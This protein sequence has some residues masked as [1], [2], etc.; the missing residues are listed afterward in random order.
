VDHAD[1]L[2]LARFFCA[3]ECPIGVFEDSL[4]VDGAD[5]FLIPGE[6]R[7]TDGAG[8]RRLLRSVNLK[9][10]CAEGVENAIREDSGLAAVGAT[11]D[12]EEFFT[13]PANKE[14]GITNG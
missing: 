4:I 1:G 3:V 11:G 13:S 12:D 9:W 5:I 6:R 14:V 8:Q 7:P 2:V 10:L